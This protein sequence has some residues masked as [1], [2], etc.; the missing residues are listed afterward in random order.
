MVRSDLGILKISRPDNWQLTMPRQVGD[1][2]QI[3]PSAGVVGNN[4]GYGVVVGAVKPQGSQS[5][6]EATNNLVTALQHGG[7]DLQPLGNA[8]PF[9]VAGIEGRSQMLQSTSPFPDANGQPQK[10]RDW[11]VTVPR[12]DGSLAY[13]VFVAPEAE[14]NR[15]TPAFNSMLK[16]V[17]FQK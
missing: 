9:T 12:P 17:T 16:S 11:L 6:D 8:Q 14:W 2:I 7:E 10:E 13:F 5:L 15:F 1:D 3:A 4:V